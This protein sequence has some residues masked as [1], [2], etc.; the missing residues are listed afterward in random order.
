MKLI[1]TKLAPETR[2]A[3]EVNQRAWRCKQRMTER[4]RQAAELAYSLKNEP[5]WSVA[6]RLLVAVDAPAGQRWKRVMLVKEL[7]ALTNE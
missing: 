1:A 6:D 7:E 3:N 4:E 2:W 5:A